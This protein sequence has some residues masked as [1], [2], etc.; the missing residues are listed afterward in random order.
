MYSLLRCVL[1]I[2]VLCMAYLA[3][4]MMYFM[5]YISIAIGLLLLWT[6]C[7]K[8]LRSNAH[9]TARW[10]T[11][12]DIPHMLEG[13]GLIVGH[14]EGRL[15]RFSGLRELISP[16]TTSRAA[17]LKFLGAFQRRPPKQLVRLT[18]A[19][20]TAVFAPTGAGKGV[21]CVVPFVLTCPDSMVIYDV[22][23]EIAILTAQARRKMGHRVVVIDPYK[24]TTQE[25]DSF[26]PLDFIDKDSETAL[27]DIRDLA[28]AL[29][30]RNGQEKEPHWSDSAEVWIAAM[31][32]TVVCFAENADKSLQSVRAL[33]TNPERM[34]AAIK[35]MCESDEMEG[36]LSRLGFQL[37]QFKDKE[38]GSTLTTTNRFLRFLDTT[39]IAESTK[40]SSFDPADLLTKKVTVYLVLPPDRM[41]AQTALVRMWMSSLLRA[42]VKGGLQT[43]TKVQFVIDEAASLGPLDCLDDAVDKLRGYGVRL[44]LIFQ[45][46]T[47][48]RKVFPDGQDQ[49]LLSNVTQVFFG[50]NDQQTAEYV[51]SRLGESTIVTSSGGTSCGRSS[52]TGEHGQ[53][54]HSSSTNENSNWQFM[55]RKL[56]KPEEVTALPDRVAITFA[57]GVPPLATRLIRYY[58]KDFKNLR[59]MGLIRTTFETACLFLPIAL[60][61]LIFTTALLNTIPKERK[62]HVQTNSAVLRPAQERRKAHTP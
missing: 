46:L 38:L 1:I 32:A 11:P 42:V 12:S 23:G 16:R 58:E 18:Q 13:D 5:P 44:L 15:S 49:T 34:Q 48:L 50:V 54:T 24:V 30:V 51:S 17:C 26:N 36:M 55:G 33:L 20:H 37:G 2:T 27:D 8:T 59:G 3:A 35:M 19:V 45:S 52:Q 14:I 9:G 6:V 53:A 25:P 56:L 21:S 22:K 28:A 47:Q 31:V 7:K 10:A 41:R 60:F 43:T 62:D 40:Q 57:P 29:V 4:L 39:A 61:V